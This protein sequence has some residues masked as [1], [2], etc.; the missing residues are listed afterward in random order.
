[1]AGGGGFAD[2]AADFCGTGEGNFV[3]VGMS[4]ERFAS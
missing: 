4:D 3:D 1:M 2:G